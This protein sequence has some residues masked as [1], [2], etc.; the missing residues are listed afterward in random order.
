MRDNIRLS[1]VTKLKH[2][3]EAHGETYTFLREKLDEYNEPMGEEKEEVCT[4]SGLFHVSRGYLTRTVSDGNVTHSKGQPML[5]VL[6][7]DMSKAIRMNDYVSVNDRTYRVNTKNNVGEY[8]VAYD[9]SLEVVL[10]GSEI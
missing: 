4:V 9:I 7:D 2:E 8:N 6:C 3:I 5:L 10:G 1:E